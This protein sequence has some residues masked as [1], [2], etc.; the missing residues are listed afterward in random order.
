MKQETKRS[1]YDFNML[2]AMEVFLAVAEMKQVTAAAE[3]LGL[4]QSAA[5]QHLKNLETGFGVTLL[6][7]S[8][9]PLSLT[10]A[11]EALQ[12]RAFTILN[13]VED[14]RSDF[15]RL[16]SSRIPVLRIG[17]LASIAT[18][19]SPDLSRFVRD[20]L[21]IDELILSASLAPEHQ[22]QL[23][24]RKLDIVV[25]SAPLSDTAGFS[26]FP[27][28]TEKFYLVLPKDYDGPIDDMADLSRNLPLVRFSAN[29]PVGR[30]TDQHL[31]RQ[32][33]NL[34]RV[35]EADRSS[36]VVAGVAAGTG[37]AILSPT[38]LADA[39]TEG[40]ELRIEPLPFAGFSRTVNLLA[41]QEDL[42]DIP[43]QLA[44][45]CAHV[46]KQA[47][48]NLFPGLSAGCEFHR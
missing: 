15:R 12:R 46:L 7:R 48:S 37:F 4:T 44:D 19:L 31:Q 2:R 22:Q 13:E 20:D 38:L 43:E 21:A 16:R 23:L 45:T 36:M 6:D 24:A 40:M 34:P 9:R 25:T 26:V 1:G 47:F 10:H 5:S 27:L 39:V 11:G 3:A 32:R 41:R 42:G 28:L 30:R 17:L 14:L 8:S 29:A 35:M 18:T 33:L